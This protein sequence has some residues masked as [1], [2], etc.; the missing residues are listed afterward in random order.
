MGSRG[1]WPSAPTVFAPS[2]EAALILPLDNLEHLTNH[3]HQLF[4]Y[5]KQFGVPVGTP[6]LYH[7]RGARCP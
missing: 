2:N 5:L 7:W 3:K 6:D 1:R 4:L